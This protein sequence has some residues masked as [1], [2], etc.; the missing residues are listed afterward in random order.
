MNEKLGVNTKSRGWHIFQIVRT[1]II[2][3]I[4]WYFDRIVDVQKSF[5]YLRNTITHFGNPLMLIC[6]DYVNQILGNIS[7]F[8]SHIVLITL[9]SL[10][11]FVVSVLKENKIDVYGEIQKKNIAIRWLSYYIPLILII[12]SLSF[13]AGDTGFMYAQY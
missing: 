5:A 12:L 7:D 11:I 4:G 9:D 10:I 3:N 1:F 6:K 2:V 8:Q 13:S